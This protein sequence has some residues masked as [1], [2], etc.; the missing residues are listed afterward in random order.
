MQISDYLNPKS[1]YL[2]KAQDTA[3]GHQASEHSSTN[4]KEYS[5]LPEDVLILVPVRNAVL[6]PGV[7]APISVGRE[8]S[9]AAV[10]EAIGSGRKIGL[11][12]QHDP[13]I[14]TPKP[15]DLYRVGTEASIVRQVTAP[16]G[17]HHL[18]CQGEQRFRVLDY[19][20]GFPFLVARVDF[21]HEPETAN[22]DI[23][24]RTR[25]GTLRGKHG[26]QESRRG[27]IVSRHRR[28]RPDDEPGIAR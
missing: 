12:L 18:V 6:F 16:D 26:H 19:L 9:I 5:R 1:F 7:V 14:N 17:N 10:R 2:D 3:D 15:A 23:E 11:L 20:P 28:G 13:A 21:I 4:S 24:A 27:C 25:E 8:N 22:K